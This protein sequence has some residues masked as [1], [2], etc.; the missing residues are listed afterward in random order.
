MR[1]LFDQYEQPENRLT[2][3]LV[4]CLARDRRLLRQFV[5]WATGEACP[6]WRNLSILEQRLPGELE[7]PDED[8]AARR[9]LPDA[10]IHD[11][12]TWSLLVESKIEAPLQRDQLDRHIRTAIRE[13]F[14]DVHLLALVTKRSG[15]PL[16][17][18]LKVIE[19][20][21][22]YSWLR[23]E[24]K[25]EWAQDLMESME[26][27][28]G[29]LVGSGYLRE[30]TLTVFSGI[31]FG[32][33]YPYN[34]REAKR[35]LHL[36]MEQLKGRANLRGR[37]E[38][39]PKAEGRPAITGT[40]EMSVWDFLRLFQARGESS[41]TK[42][43]HLTLSI[44]QERIFACVTVPN[45][46]RAEY[47]RRLLGRGLEHFVN[48]CTEVQGRLK[49]VLRNANGAVPWVHLVQRRYPTQRS[50]P[51]VDASLQFDLRTTG[52]L[53][54]AP[55]R[56]KTVKTQREWIEAA[57][58]GL[59]NRNSNL[60]FAIGVVFPYARCRAVGTPQILEYVAEVW[61]SCRPLIR[62]IVG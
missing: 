49:K 41:F 1:N 20:R 37:L 13:G 61:L 40:E 12:N 59:A 28:E 4:C 21:E 36:C 44:Q 45:G 26:V 7:A 62:T 15:I 23:R 9:G 54:V 43:P 30:G 2:H 55:R 6:P 53:P 29:K 25:S 42:C 33:D 10:W 60:Q 56:R 16:P 19:W 24:G 14:R 34:Y 17:S 18:G 32:K 46:I 22:L 51:I 57:Y 5:Q 47:R 39:D 3:A 52:A 38:M 35:L 58:K 27:T 50:I 31:P 48:L 11:S 8:V